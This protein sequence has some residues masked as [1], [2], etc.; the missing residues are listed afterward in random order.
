MSKV[1]RERHQTVTGS[2]NERSKKFVHVENCV[3]AG[4]SGLTLE[5]PALRGDTCT[6]V[7]HN[8]E[9]LRA[10][11]NVPNTATV[12]SLPRLS[13]PC[14][15]RPRLSSISRFQAPVRI[16]CEIVEKQSVGNLEE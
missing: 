7:A 14:S 9:Q 4:A 15:A 12:A 1:W 16:L 6:D 2:G 8:P 13:T 3:D 10:T 5:R 11:I